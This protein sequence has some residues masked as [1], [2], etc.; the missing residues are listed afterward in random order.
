VK[1]FGP[2]FPQHLVGEGAFRLAE[3]VRGDHVRFVRNPAYHGTRPWQE[4]EGA[5]YLDSI[6][7]RFVGD[8]GV[9]GQILKTGEAN[10]V[11]GLPAQAVATYAGSPAY[12]LLAGYQSGNG[13]MFSLNTARPAL[14]D[15][16]VR[17]A[18]RYAYDQDRMNQT[19][20]GGSYV[21]VKGPLTKY[22]LYYWKGADNAYRLD[23]ARA[24]TI[25]DEA[26][27][28]ENSRTGVREKDG[29]PLALTMVMLHH[30]EIGEYLAAQL[31]AIGAD[32]RVEVVPGP[33]QLQRAQSG[34]FDLIY[35]RL[36]SYEPDLLFDEFYSKNYRP[37]G[38]AWTRYQNAA[39][40]KALLDSQS[41]TDPA[42]RQALF[43]EAQKIVTDEALY[44]PTLDDPQ[45]Y[46]MTRKVHGF[47]LG[48]TG[49]WYFLNDVSVDK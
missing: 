8:Q 42:R 13:M 24:R 40:D 3:W 48:A 27:W 12:Q 44:L 9:L 46:A 23:P 34:D 5:A 16:R 6:T 30:K 19:L 36:R 29:R 33:V 10:L 35:E 43:T 47:R 18:L 41:T 39:L 7:V 28:K 26:G 37:G 45:Y 1:Q 2:S 11:A 21:T 4:H 22:T 38:W 14:N 49:S 17:R 25:L 32:L 20:Y 31:R 15:V